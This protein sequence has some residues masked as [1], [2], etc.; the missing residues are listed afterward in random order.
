MRIDLLSH[1][2]PGFH[3]EHYPGRLVLELEEDHQTRVVEGDATLKHLNQVLSIVFV[4]VLAQQSFTL[5]TQMGRVIYVLLFSDTARVLEL[6]KGIA[7]RL[8]SVARDGR[9]AGQGVQET[10]ATLIQIPDYG[11]PQPKTGPTLWEL[12]QE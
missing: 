10:S 7:P 4:E 8:A 9:A 11:A 6:R 2:Q 12:I 1:V 3:P 5:M